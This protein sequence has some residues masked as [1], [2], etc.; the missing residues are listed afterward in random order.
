MANMTQAGGYQD[1]P[2]Q[3]QERSWDGSAWTGVAARLLPGQARV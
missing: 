1:P 3:G 2:N